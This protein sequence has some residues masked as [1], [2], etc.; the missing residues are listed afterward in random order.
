MLIDNLEE[1]EKEY[2]LNR[3]TR[4]AFSCSLYARIVKGVIER[5]TVDFVIRTEYSIST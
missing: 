3:G 5:G 1:K 4:L 2:S